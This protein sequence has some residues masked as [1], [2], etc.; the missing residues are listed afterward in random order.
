MLPLCTIVSDLRSLSIAYCSALR[1]SRSVP[2][3]DTGLMPMLEVAGKRIFLTP[4]SRIRKS[5]TFFAPSD[6][7][8]HSIPA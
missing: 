8:S 5:M 6:S 2:S 3:R 7:A 4:S 1:T